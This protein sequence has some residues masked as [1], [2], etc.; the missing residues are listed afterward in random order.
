MCNVYIPPSLKHMKPY[1]CSPGQA[2]VVDVSSG[3]V[4]PLGDPGELLIRAYS[5]MLEYWDDP[6]K[7]SEAI[8]KDRWYRTG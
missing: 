2:K 6:E 1:L 7:T 3:E 5:V 8:A 4:V